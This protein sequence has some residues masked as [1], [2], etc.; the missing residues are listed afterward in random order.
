MGDLEEG[1]GLSEVG[2]DLI[3]LGEI[4]AGGD[5]VGDGPGGHASGFSGEDAVEGIFDDK[6]A[7]RGEV[8]A[9]GSFEVE[10]GCGFDAGGVTSADGCLEVG[11]KVEAG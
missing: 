9:F 11:G 6:A 3:G 1:E 7:V 8:E 4:K 2:E 10:I 5:A